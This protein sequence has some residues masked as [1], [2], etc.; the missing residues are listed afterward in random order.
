MTPK[1]LNDPC[2][3]DAHQQPRGLGF[4]PL[5]LAIS[6]KIIIFS[7]FQPPFGIPKLFEKGKDENTYKKLYNYFVQEVA[8]RILGMNY[9][10]IGRKSRYHC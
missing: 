8:S 5:T 6:I 1:H 10:A 2:K 7:H 4:K 3:C 9:F